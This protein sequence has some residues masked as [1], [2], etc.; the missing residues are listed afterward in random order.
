MTGATPLTS[1]MPSPPAG[2]R[3]DGRAMLAGED[4]RY[5]W[6]VLGVVG[7]G[8][9]M[10]TLDS[11]IVNVALPILTRDFATSLVVSQWVIL[12]YVLCITGLLLPAG[13][14]ADMV[15]RRGVFLSGFVLFAGAS[16]LCGLAPGI[17]WL[18]AARVLQGVG[19]A[20]VQANTAALLTQAF[21]ASERG[22]A[23]GLN[24]SIVSVGLLSG[25]VI[26][27]A[28]TQYL[29]WRWA[30]YVNLPISLVAAPVGWRLLRPSPVVP[31][32]RFDLVGSALFLLAVVALLLGLNQGEVWG[33]LSPLTIGVLAAAVLLAAAFLRVEQHVAQPT[34]ELSLFRNHGFS[35]AA[36]TAF[37]SF[38]ALSPVT[39]LMPFYFELVLGLPADQAGLLLVAIPATVA[40]IAPFSGALS[41]HLGPR[42]IAA[43][44]LLVETLG[45]ALLIFLPPAGGALAAAVRL[46]IVGAGQAL[47]QSPN[48]SALF[49]SVP[50]SRLGLVGGFQAL[51][52]NL[53][54]SLGQVLAGTL[55]TSVVM[56]A[57]GSAARV[58]VEAPPAA[59]MAGFRAV[60][61]VSAALAAVAM[62]VSLG[63][64]P[65]P[66]GAHRRADGTLTTAAE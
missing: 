64:P 9:Y 51:T 14:L 13:R 6:K 33:W 40:C 48:S 43:A 42:L 36:A 17:G 37:L 56:A 16:A 21:P 7:S 34:I 32:Q 29:G 2:P 23:L 10:V 39:L 65:A 63:R 20:L 12:G 31:D 1:A 3:P 35:V 15:G 47:F 22:R 49:G 66:A 61:T 18:I 53:G 28:I 41:D 55:W 60:F 46:V 8:V 24:S 30:F 58:A 50:R 26:G 62:L 59:M 27:G 38:L 25:P 45:L 52:R 54:Q 11:G 19:G 4:P 5:K 44:G 57:A